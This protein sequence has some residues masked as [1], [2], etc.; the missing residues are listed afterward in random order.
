MIARFSPSQDLRRPVTQPSDVPAV[1]SNDSLDPASTPKLV[2]GR[3]VLTSD[4]VREGGMSVVQKAFDPV[5]SRLCA[6]KRMKIGSQDEL[7]WRESFNREVKALSDLSEHP[8]IVSLHGAGNDGGGYY[9]ALE[10][11]PGESSRLGGPEKGR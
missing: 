9:M 4:P 7:Q 8:N 10:W 2:D 5:E 11:V 3:Y 1:S 6:I